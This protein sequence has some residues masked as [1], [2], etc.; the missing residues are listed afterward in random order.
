MS[1]IKTFDECCKE[2]A[3]E[4]RCH[5]LVAFK[6]PYAEAANRYASQ[7]KAK[8]DELEK[9]IDE[10]KV[11]VV[12]RDLQLS[13]AK[14]EIAGLEVLQHI[15]DGALSEARKENEK[16]GKVL[17]ETQQDYRHEHL[18]VLRL[19]SELT[20][21]KQ[22]KERLVEKLRQAGRMFERTMDVEKFL[23]SLSKQNK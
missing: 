21:L 5:D 22:E 2:V 1:E 18:E 11:M 12:D 3:K 15:T 10:L 9:E 20:S 17:G 7:Y 23:S 13:E 4:Y 19:Q 14:K 8:V 6:E 16:I